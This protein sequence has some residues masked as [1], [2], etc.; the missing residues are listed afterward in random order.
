MAKI[1]LKLDTNSRNLWSR[2]TKARQNADYILI[3]EI[4][5]QSQPVY[6]SN[7]R[8]TLEKKFGGN[9]NNKLREIAISEKKSNKTR[10]LKL[11]FI[12]D[13]S[14]DLLQEEFTLLISCQNMTGAG[15]SFMDN[16]LYFRIPKVI[17]SPEIKQ[18]YFP[19]DGEEQVALAL[20][21]LNSLCIGGND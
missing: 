3:A 13:E 12:N 11:M 5:G 14:I 1:I 6:A 4:P 2:K 17:G 19:D 16:L 8:G 18:C 15:K 10:L 7:I 21:L 20:L 9:I